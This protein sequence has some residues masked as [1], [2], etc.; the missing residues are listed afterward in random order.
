MTTAEFA[1]AN[2]IS[3][4][5]ALAA[6]RRLAAERLVVQVGKYAWKWKR[7]VVGDMSMADLE[8]L[9]GKVRAKGKGA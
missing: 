3:V 5:G 8:G 6:L 1:K 7:W 4:Y 2:G 9:A